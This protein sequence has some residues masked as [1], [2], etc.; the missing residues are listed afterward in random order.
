MRIESVLAVLFIL[1]LPAC[2][3]RPPDADPIIS[4]RL[5]AK[6]DF[7]ASSSRNL[8]GNVAHGAEICMRVRR[9]PDY[10]D[11]LTFEA[12]MVRDCSFWNKTI[13][14][15]GKIMLMAGAIIGFPVIVPK[16]QP[17]WYILQHEQVHFAIMQIEVLQLNRDIQILAA[18]VDEP[19]EGIMDLRDSALVRANE[20]HARFDGDTSGTYDTVSLEAWVRRM[21]RDLRELCSEE[22][23]CPVRRL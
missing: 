8:W 9:T 6:D 1:L 18:A 20:R 7:W 12:V 21:E 13:G 15:L 22:R 19:D 16:K 2:A 10:L 17:D 4:Y 11:S 3:S 14:P 23:V 5:V